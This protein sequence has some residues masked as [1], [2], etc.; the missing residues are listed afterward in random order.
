MLGD[1][2]KEKFRTYVYILMTFR[3]YQYEV[4]CIVERTQIFTVI[5]AIIACLITGCLQLTDY[6]TVRDT[7]FVLLNKRYTH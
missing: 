7:K 6:R 2:T 1:K 4:Q 5:E 3:K